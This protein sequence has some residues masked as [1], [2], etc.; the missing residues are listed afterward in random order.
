[1][2]K[3]DLRLRAAT[4]RP[5]F[6]ELDGVRAIAALMVMVFHFGQDW[7]SSKLLVFGQ[8]GVDLFFVLSGFLITTILLR[9]R[10]GDWHEIRN[11]YIRRTLRIFPLYYGYLLG[12][13]LLGGTVSLCYWGYLQNL[14]AAFGG[15]LHLAAPSGPAHF[16]SLGVEEQFYLV[17]PFLILFWPR[18]WLAHAMWGMVVFSILLRVALIGSSVDTFRFTL[19]RLDGLGAGGLLAYYYFRG[20]LGRFKPLLMALAPLAL[21]SLV[22]E[23]MAS[24]GTGVAWVEVMKYTSATVL[25]VALIGLLVTTEDSWMH[26]ILRTKPMR[27]IGGVSYG[28][29]VYHPA[30]FMALPGYLGGLPILAKAAICFAVV[31]LVAL[32]SFYGFERPFVGLKARL[33]SEK[34]FRAVTA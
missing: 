32:A 17:W 16:W 2:L 22:V 33:A 12:V 23:K 1:M 4:T 25:Y 28:M 7:Y 6:P 10:Q 27:G 14:A 24:H 30:I 18:R 34:P 31:Y 19:T 8:T 20:V 11:F 15:P 21:L 26:R 5:Y 13:C 29:Y 9:S 3:N